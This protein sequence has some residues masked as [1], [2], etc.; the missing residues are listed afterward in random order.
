MCF[1]SAQSS[2]ETKQDYVGLKLTVNV[3]YLT[4][5]GSRSMCIDFVILNAN[6]IRL[7]GSKYYFLCYCAG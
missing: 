4:E 6:C 2:I 7:V 3:K 1:K 5:L